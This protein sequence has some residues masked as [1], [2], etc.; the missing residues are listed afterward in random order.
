MSSHWHDEHHQKAH[1]LCPLLEHEN[2]IINNTVLTEVLNSLKKNNYH[3][4]RKKVIHSLLDLGVVSILT[5]NDYIGSIKLF[6]YYNHAI[7]FSNCTILKTMQ[8]NQVNK[9]VSFE[10]VSIFFD[11]TAS[12]SLPILV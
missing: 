11:L 10:V 12:S 9:I 7:N 6:N 2:K 3:W 1:L 4:D 5:S 8:N